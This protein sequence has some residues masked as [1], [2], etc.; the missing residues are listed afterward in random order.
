MTIWFARTT[1]SA[2]TR[3]TLGG[4]LAGDW[5]GERYAWTS[6]AIIGLGVV[7]VLSL[8]LF[9]W[10]QATTES[11]IMPLSLFRI[12]A[13][14]NSYVIQA[15]QGLA[16]TGV[17]VYLL[18]YLQVVRDVSATGTG[19][20][21]VF[22]A[23]GILVSGLVGERLGLPLRAAM[24]TG[25]ATATADLVLLFA[26]TGTDTSLWVLR[27]E[28]TLL[29]LGFG[30]M[31]GRL[32]TVVQ[33]A[34]PPPRMGVAISGVRFF[35]LLG[36]ATGAALL[37]TVL[38]RLFEAEERGVEMTAIPTLSGSE[39]ASAATAFTDSLSV[40][41]GVAG[42]FMALAVLF[43]TRLRRPDPAGAES[44]PPEPAPDPAVRSA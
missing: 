23:G 3:R 32:I 44:A 38:R 41:F 10:R 7:G 36:G 16:L 29:G 25:T 5:G 4:A 34:V 26:C 43:S 22:L 2:R 33:E 14:R 24:V 11:P 27:A 35:Q 37:G 12:P 39:R 1:S 6:P 18:T 19:T 31:I 13:V 30:L 28:L 9:L 8:A 42:L 21:L 40:V 20:F 17:I 15:L